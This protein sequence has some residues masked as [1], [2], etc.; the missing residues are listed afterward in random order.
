MAKIIS[1]KAFDIRFPTSK[2]S[3]GSDA[4]NPNPDYSSAY[5]ILKTDHEKK[6]EGHGMTFTIGRGNDLCVEAIRLLEPFIV[7]QNLNNLKNDLGPIWRKMTDDSHLRWLGPHKGVIH[8]AIAAV[9]NAVWDLVAKLHE[10]PVWELL[11]KM[12]SEEI[13]NLVNW[14]YISDEIKPEEAKKHLEKTLS[15]V[16][17]KIEYIKKN[18]Y[19]AYTTSTGWIGYKDEKIKLLLKDAISK[20]WNYFKM[21]VGSGLDNDIRRSKMIREIIGPNRY[22]MMDT[23]QAWGVDEAIENMK[24]LSKFKPAWIE[25]PTSPDD[26]LGHAKIARELKNIPVATGEHCHNA[27]MFKQFMQAKAMQVCQLDSCRLASI[28]EIIAVLLLAWKFNIKVC[29]HAGGVGLCEYVQHISMFDFT[30]ISNSTEGKVLEYIDHLHEH[31]VDPVVVKNGFY[32]APTQPGY[33]IQM[34]KETLQDYN[35]QTGKIWN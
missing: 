22:L 2:Q 18:G 27:V 19:P 16:D 28:N 13:I 31:F 23:N 8:L 14:K 29:P 6:L 25:E 11:S 30:R 26:I 3:D 4:M 35:F 20:G 5:C 10:K 21:K 1:L 32:Q 17:S 15:G 9:M 33:S 34:K 12:E 7:G 24:V